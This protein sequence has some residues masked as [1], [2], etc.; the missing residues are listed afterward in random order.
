MSDD[1]KAGDSRQTDTEDKSAKAVVARRRLLRGAAGTAPVL[2]TLHSRPVLAGMCATASASASLNPSGI[3][4]AQGKAFDCTGALRPAQWLALRNQDWPVNK[5][6]TTF[7]DVFSPNP[8]GNAKLTDVLAY[9]D[10]TGE[11]A[12]AKAC[13]ATYLNF[14]KGYVP[15]GFFGGGTIKTVWEHGRTG[16]FSPRIGATW[17]VDKVTQWL[18][19][20]WGERWLPWEGHP[21]YVG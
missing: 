5:G 15:P 7:K 21:D 1:S 16:S 20:T 17:S 2:M 6:S 8:Y 3:R 18:A 9:T 10:D 19:T 12:L 11:K 14:M 13:V 4:R